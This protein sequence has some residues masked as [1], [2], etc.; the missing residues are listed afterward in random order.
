MLGTKAHPLKHGANGKVQEESAKQPTQH[1]EAY[2]E[3]ALHVH[4]KTYKAKKMVPPRPD[5]PEDDELWGL[6]SSVGG[7]VVPVVGLE[8]QPC[9]QAEQCSRAK[10]CPTSTTNQDQAK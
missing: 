4:S 6:G 9:G 2:K 5:E 7:T 10:F 8:P 1:G 3:C